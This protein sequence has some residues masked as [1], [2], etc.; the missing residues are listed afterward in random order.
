M[1][2]VLPLVV[3]AAF[4]VAVAFFVV[5]ALDLDLA[6]V[7]SESFA[8]GSATCAVVKKDRTRC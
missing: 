8:T 7:P 2:R 3:V 4:F 1:R 6:L 5:A